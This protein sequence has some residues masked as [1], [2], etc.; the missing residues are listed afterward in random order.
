MVDWI[1]QCRRFGA[2]NIILSSYSVLKE[3]SCGRY[4][5]KELI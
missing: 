4:P 5:T 1:S 3:L 2:V